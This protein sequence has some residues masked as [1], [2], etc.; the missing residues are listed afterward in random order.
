MA[1]KT[2]E[3][4]G[5]ATAVRHPLHRCYRRPD[6]KDNAAVQ[7]HFSGSH[8]RTLYVPRERDERNAGEWWKQNEA[9]GEKREGRGESERSDRQSEVAFVLAV[10]GQGE[11]L[12]AGLR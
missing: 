4:E 12:V 7:T 3:I 8:K 1:T 5:G 11:V 10:N 9:V 6:Q 2:L